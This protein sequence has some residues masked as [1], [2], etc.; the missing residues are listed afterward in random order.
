MF[1]AAGDLIGASTFES[2][3]QKDKP[4]IDALN[5][6]GPRG[7][8]GGQPRVR[9]GLQRPGRPG[10]E[11]VRRH[12]QPVRRRELE[13][14]RAPTC[15]SRA[16]TRDAL[17]RHLDEDVGRRSR[18]ASSVRSPRTCPSLVSPAG[19]ADIKVTDIVD[20]ANAA[21]DELKAD[22]ADVVVLLVHE[23][24]RRPLRAVGDRP[25]LGL[26]PDRQRCRRRRR[27]DRLRPH[28]PGVQLLVPGA[29]LDR[30]GVRSP[31][32][33]WS[34]PVSTARSSTSSCS[35]STRP[36][37]TSSPRPRHL[38]LKSCGATVRD[39]PTG[40]RTTRSTRPPRPSWTTRWRRPP[41]SVPQVLG[42]ID[43]PFNR[44]KLANGT[45]ENRGGE[46]TLGNLVAEVQRWAT[47]SET[48]GSA[49][50]AFMNP[51][52]L[53]ADMVG[54]GTG[55][56]PRD[57]TY[58]QAADV[59]PFANTLVN[60]DLTGAQ[61]KKVL[62]QQWQ[63]DADGNVPTRPFLRLGTSK[64]FTLHLRPEPR[65]GLAHHRHVARRDDDRPGPD[66]LGDRELVPGLRRRQLLGVRQRHQQAGHRQVRPHGHGRLHGRVRATP[67]R[68]RWTT[69][70]TRSA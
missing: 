35:P 15:A 23:G 52:G 68:C 19:I 39:D 46:S 30:E 44:A 69:S 34:R 47:E 14:H 38:A 11:A 54:V 9:P 27:R 13:V 40:R 43:G 16:T 21:A 49:Q 57:L 58:R 8:G 26:R 29:G 61:I 32:A 45:T 48:A 33:R 55:A 3:I 42:K 65:R 24:R 62:E 12:H 37:V 17:P 20:E 41:C 66:L 28:P 59:Q 2:F 6:A 4:T 36:P 1:A 56:F 31:S 7:V 70:S 25:E 50:I 5:E 18:S 51:G 63:R 53:R 60:M 10:D 64:G 22:G 67:L